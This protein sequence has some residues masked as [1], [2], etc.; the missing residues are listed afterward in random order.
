MV[1]CQ[2]HVLL[3]LNFLAVITDVERIALLQVGG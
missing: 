3:E 1:I 2:P